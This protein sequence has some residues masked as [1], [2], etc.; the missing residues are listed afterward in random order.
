MI[1]LYDDYTHVH[2][3]RRRFMDALAALTGGAAAAA[4][5]APL[6][7]ANPA[8]AQMVEEND[9][10]LTVETVTYPGASGQM[11]GYLA[12]PFEVMAGALPAVI[13]I[14]ENR[15]LN[16]HTRDVA[17]RFAVEGFTALAPDFLSPEGG[18]P[19]DEDMARELIGGLGEEDLVGNL[20]AS[21]EY[22]R[23]RD[24][25]REAAVGAVGFCWGGTQVGRLAVADPELR[26][27]VVFY[28]GQPPVEAVPEIRAR[29]LLHYAGLDERINAGIPDFQA[30]LDAAGTDY[31]LHMYDGANHAFFNDTSEARYDP[32]AAALAWERTLAFLRAS[33]GEA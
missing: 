6:I 25:A 31:E 29:L 3:D 8:A 13:V 7:A 2:L 15:G 24:E 9:A 30:A 17:R 28:G 20:L 4:S 26:A 18:T 1:R 21:A 22:L 23:A 14:H 5:V 27:A 10:R 12:Y 16:D 32:E 19:A 33:L 11:L